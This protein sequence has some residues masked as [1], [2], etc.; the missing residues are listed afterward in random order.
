MFMSL[1]KGTK[2]FLYL[3]VWLL[4]V[5][6]HTVSM[7]CIVP[8]DVGLLLVDAI[9]HA[10]VFAGLGLLLWHILWYGK[11]ETLRPFQRITNYV[12]LALLFV[13][14]WLGIGYLCNYILLKEIAIQLIP[15]L[16]IRGMI[17]LLLYLV[18][19]LSCFSTN[20]TN[21]NPD[22]DNLPVPHETEDSTNA[23]HEIIDRITVR[24]GQKLHLIKIQE[25]IYIQAD[26]DYVQV[27]TKEGNYLK[28]Q[29]MKFFEICLPHKSFVRIHRSYIVN[30]EHIARIESYGKQNQQV[31]LKNGQWLKVSISGYKALKEAL[32]L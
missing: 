7:C 14:L 5:L 32:Q 20:S 8:V 24:V 4:Y 29:T 18:L 23:K 30:V 15:T 9:V 1:K 10:I 31:T 6:L 2:N 12:V 22:P 17:G 25:I 13:T 19:I 16:P 11:Y 3:L 27:I 26:G 21:N 28:E